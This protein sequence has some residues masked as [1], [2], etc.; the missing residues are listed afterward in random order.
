MLDKK[1]ILG[2][3]LGYLGFETARAYALGKVLFNV[4]VSNKIAVIK[5]Q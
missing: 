5:T 3:S 2:N 1:R 4:L